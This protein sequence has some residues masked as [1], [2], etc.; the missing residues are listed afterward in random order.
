MAQSTANQF[1]QQNEIG[2]SK[3]AHC[4]YFDY[5][6]ASRKEI[7]KIVGKR[8][9]GGRVHYLVKWRSMLQR[10]DSWENEDYLSSPTLKPLLF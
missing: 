5:I 10:E 1:Q 8:I 7:E 2:C 6:M 9:E 4:G 3:L